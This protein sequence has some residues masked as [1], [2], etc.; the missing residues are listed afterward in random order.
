MKKKTIY[1]LICIGGLHTFLYLYLIPFVIFPVYGNSGLK[2]A[3]AIAIAIS[4]TIIMTILIE[5]SNRSK[6]DEKD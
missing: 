2:V 5:K 6:K 4:I 3:V 1:K